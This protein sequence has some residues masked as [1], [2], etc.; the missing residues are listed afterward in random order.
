MPS[1]A[2]YQTNKNAACNNNNK[3]NNKRIKVTTCE[4]VAVNAVVTGAET[5]GA[6]AMAFVPPMM[7]KAGYTE[8]QMSIL[9][10]LCKSVYTVKYPSLPQQ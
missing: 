5:A 6:V 8:T 2:D 7:L 3:N 9:F 10:G 4:L 1:S